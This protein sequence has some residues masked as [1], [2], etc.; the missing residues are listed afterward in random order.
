MYN[1]SK[2]TLTLSTNTAL[3]ET[4]KE[5]PSS[6]RLKFMNPIARLEDLDGNKYIMK[7]GT[8][9]LSSDQWQSDMM[10]MS[11]SVPSITTG[12]RNIRQEG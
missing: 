6:S 8:F 3:S 11:Y 1:Q 7:R 12:T 2:P 10:Q 5:Y 4:N 9:S